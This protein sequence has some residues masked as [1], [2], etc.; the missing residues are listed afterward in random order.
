MY[1]VQTSI[2]LETQE[3]TQCFLVSFL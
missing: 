3:K 2:V 1:M